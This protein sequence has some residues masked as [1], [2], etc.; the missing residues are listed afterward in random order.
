MKIV[1]WHLSFPSLASHPNIR[2]L[3]PVV[4][5]EPDP[6]KPTDLPDPLADQDRPA[7][8]SLDYSA[9][10]TT[11]APDKEQMRDPYAAL[12]IPA[13]RNFMGAFILSTFGSQIQTTAVGWAIYK[14]TGN[15]LDLGWIGLVLAIPM[16]LL[17]LPAGQLAD[18]YSR[19]YLFL[20][21]QICAMTCAS[22]LMMLSWRY[23]NYP[24]F[25]GV[26]Y[27]L[28]ALSA[29][30]GTL[31]RPGREALMA[32]IVPNA[33]FPNAVT[34][35]ST[36][37]ELSAMLGP[38]IG[39][40]IIWL[41]GAAAAYGVAT[42]MFIVSVL[43][44]LM[45]P[46]ILP[47]RKHNAAGVKELL[48]GLRFVFNTK[49]LLAAMTLDL[50]AVLFGG[51]TFLLPVFASDVLHVGAFGFGW[52]RAAPS[53][54]AVCMAMIVAHRPPLKNA[55]WA[56]LL[57]VAGF[58]AATLVFGLSRNYALSFAMLLFTG[59]FDN[60]SVYVRHSLV[61]LITP[62]HMRGR[63]SAVNQIFVGSSNELGG[64]ESGL[65][66]WAFGS[67][68]A[69]VVLGG[70]M[71]ILVVAAVAVGFPQVRKLKSLHDVKPADV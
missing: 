27:A 30:G 38:A 33:L 17:S 16:L 52:L 4:S 40:L 64:L 7:R 42:G 19:K 50:F 44:V 43:L 57:T 49:L 54:G 26:T 2:K 69:S 12:R 36:A 66:A 61:P 9:P 37:F 23:N 62:D 21:M 56:L 60:I 15:V 65:T 5:S 59:V 24:H 29:I 20:F 25:I 14:K 51:A 47:E 58:G 63:V 28:L 6:Q 35:N 55:G 13:F 1:I 71:S 41:S 48:A 8:V 10:T 3:D 11:T 39:G 22:G 32:R 53:I 46:D 67:A 18:L 70:I 45:L 34:W 68:A 31:G